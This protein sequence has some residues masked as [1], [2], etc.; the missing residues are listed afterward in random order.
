MCES[1]RPND[2]GLASPVRPH[3][4]KY[5][6]RN[7][8][9]RTAPA[10]ETWSPTT[11]RTTDSHGVASS[12]ESLDMDTTYDWPATDMPRTSRTGMMHRPKADTANA[13]SKTAHAVSGPVPDM[14]DA[15][16]GP[17]GVRTE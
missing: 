2:G 6:S 12:R 16:L 13:P 3:C 8:H 4:D 1:G 7:L 9:V 15:A 11:S 17:D 14:T 10:S 5:Q